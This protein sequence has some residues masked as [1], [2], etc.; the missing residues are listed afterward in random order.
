M[1]LPCVPARLQRKQSISSRP[2]WP[3]RARAP[4]RRARLGK[5]PWGIE[6][7]VSQM[8]KTDAMRNASQSGAALIGL[9]QAQIE[10]AKE[11]SVWR[12]FI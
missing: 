6:F 7:Q 3:P 5:S 2:G 9:H 4:E 8:A 1:R 10:T 12:S 11:N